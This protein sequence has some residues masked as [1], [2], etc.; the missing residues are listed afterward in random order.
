MPETW[1]EPSVRDEDRLPWLESAETD[2][3]RGASVWR[4]F[5]LAVLLVA[6]AV[7]LILGAHAFKTRGGSDGNGALINAC[8]SGLTVSIIQYGGT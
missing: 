3:R 7:G 1:R 2:Y 4:I 6:L 8:I 5:L